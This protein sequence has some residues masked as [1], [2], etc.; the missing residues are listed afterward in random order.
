MDDSDFA[1]SEGQASAPAHPAAAGVGAGPWKWL[2][3]LLFLG[4]IAVGAWYFLS[5]DT[6]EDQ[7]RTTFHIL[8][9]SENRILFDDP[10]SDEPTMMERFEE[11]ENVDFEPSFQGSVDTMLDIQAGADPYDAV[12]PASSIWLNLG[13]TQGTVSRVESIMGSPVVFGVK[14]SKAEE[15]G[16]VGTDVTVE[17]ILAAAES[18]ELRYMMSSATQ[19]NSGAMAYLGYL[20]AFAGRPDVL[21]SEHLHDPEL[22][23]KTKR[24]LGEVDRTAGASGFLRDLFLESYGEYDG[25]VNNESAIIT[26]NKSLIERGEADLLH[27]IYPVD[28]L[29]LADWPLGYVDR[30]DETK[31]A[32][33]DK[34]QAYLLSDEV[35]QELLDQGRRTNQFVYPMNE[36][37][38]DPEVFNPD[39]GIDPGRVIVPI[40]VP[41]AGVT[42]EALNLYQTTFRKPSFTVLALDYSGSM[43]GDGEEDLEEAMQVLLDQE[44]AAKYFLQR[45]ETDITVVIPFNGA[46][47]D[48]WRADGSDPQTLS[49]LL[50]RVVSQETGG[51]TNIYDPMIAALD[52]MEGSLEGYAPAIIL[53]TDGHSNEGNFSQFEARW[54]EES[55]EGV[56][57]YSILFG[58]ASDEQLTQIEELTAG[59]VYDG[60]DGLIDALRDSFG[61]V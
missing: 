50:S 42:L 43:A 48:I 10:D 14:R 5:D 31:S 15:L 6:P 52:E 33:F 32:L 25:M 16:W 24:L 3:P 45:T 56:P 34:L 61:N 54:S 22:A 29:A 47:I 9:G 19:S 53:L 36:D 17:D 46:V 23:E 1:S 12:W 30:E 59:D 28:G 7:N 58:E 44:E 51:E 40:T 49:A 35:Q 4:T 38:I 57:V 41:A 37:T 11:E 2:L 55:P 8:T 26:A 20:Y 13:N 39:W 18:G 27:V 60:R 21:T